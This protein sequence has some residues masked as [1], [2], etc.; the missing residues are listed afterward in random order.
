MKKLVINKC[1]GGFGISHEAA[2]LYGERANLN[3]FWFQDDE[4]PSLGI[5][6]YYTGGVKDDNNYWFP[7]SI[8]RDDPI[9]VQIVEELGEKVN[10]R[11]SELKIVEIPEDVEYTIEEYDGIEWIAEKHRTWQ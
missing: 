10:T 7:R 11:Y 6:H 8:Q 5:T 3:L 2:L 4:Y 9:L 1:F